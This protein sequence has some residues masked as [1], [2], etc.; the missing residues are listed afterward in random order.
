MIFYNSEKED[1]HKQEKTIIVTCNCGC[2]DQINI[3]KYDYGE[4]DKDYY[5]TISSGK[6]YSEQRGIWR[7]IK[8]RLKNAWL[9]LRGKEYRLC[10]LNVTQDQLKQLSKNIEDIIK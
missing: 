8:N 10:D 4:D 5:I 1:S 9:C 2:E 3:K 7:T 6:F